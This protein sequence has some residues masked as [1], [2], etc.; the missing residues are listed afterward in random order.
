MAAAPEVGEGGRELF[1]GEGRMGAP[2]VEGE[3]CA[4]RRMV[5]MV[6]VRPGID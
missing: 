4:G 2:T 5:R 6:C 1:G 3:G